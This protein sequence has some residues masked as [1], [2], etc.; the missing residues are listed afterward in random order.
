[1]VLA[2]SWKSATLSST[3]RA[4][5][6]H[7]ISA[8]KP[9]LMK[10]TGTDDEKDEAKA[11]Q[12]WPESIEFTTLDDDGVEPL[13][14]GEGVHVFVMDTGVDIYHPD[15]VGAAYLEADGHFN[16]VAPANED[17]CDADPECMLRYGSHKFWEGS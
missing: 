5:H 1:M 8:D 14:L 7:Q 9:A 10:G 16:A 15:L 17:D 4:W 13:N 6:L 12:C 2:S 3:H 11:D